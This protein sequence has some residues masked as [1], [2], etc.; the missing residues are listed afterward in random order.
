MSKNALDMGG[1]KTASMPL[2]S[3]KPPATSL[4]AVRRSQ[5]NI[6]LN[7]DSAL[8]EIIGNKESMISTYNNR[9]SSQILN[10][11]T[12][13]DGWVKGN[14][15][16]VQSINITMNRSDANLAEGRK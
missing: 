9:N 3:R 6:K 15:V 16:P 8:P 11:T 12:N 2:T 14:E 7:R 5:D 1:C 10:K 4:P 13:D